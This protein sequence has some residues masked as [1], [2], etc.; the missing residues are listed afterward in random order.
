MQTFIPYLDF[1]KTAKVLDYRRLGKQRVE[2][3]QILQILLGETEKVGWRNHPVVKMWRGYEAALVEYAIAICEEWI[4][5][6]YRDSLLPYFK[7]RK[8]HVVIVPTWL[9]QKFCHQYQSCL[10]RKNPEHYSKYFGVSSDLPF[11]WPKSDI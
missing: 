3:K 5:R 9:T 8:H 11:N 2:A 1:R 6:G 10:L 7:E 4:S